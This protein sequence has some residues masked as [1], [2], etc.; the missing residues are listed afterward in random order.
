[1]ELRAVPS[2]H[3]GKRLSVHVRQMHVALPVMVG[4]RVY[5]VYIFVSLLY[6]A[7][8]LYHSSIFLALMYLKKGV[9]MCTKNSQHITWL[10]FKGISKG[11]LYVFGP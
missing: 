4:F 10:A 5:F 1:M 2:D 9:E 8:L 7:P 6:T 11:S 3:L